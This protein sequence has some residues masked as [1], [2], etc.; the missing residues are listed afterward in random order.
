MKVGDLVKC[1]ET[2]TPSA[3][4]VGVIV[5]VYGHKVEVLG[6]SV[7][8]WDGVKG[9]KTWDKHDLTLVKR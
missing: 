5:G 7:V 9:K 2:I 1:P 3:A 4:Y 6:G 8:S